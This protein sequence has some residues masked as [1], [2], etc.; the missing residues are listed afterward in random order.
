MASFNVTASLPKTTDFESDSV[1]DISLY[2]QFKT[3]LKADFIPPGGCLSSISYSTWELFN[4]LSSVVDVC[5][6]II[7]ILKKANCDTCKESL[8][9]NVT[10]SDLEKLVADIFNSQL[11]FSNKSQIFN[12]MRLKVL[13]SSDDSTSNTRK[14]ILCD[15]IIGY[16]F[17]GEI[18]AEHITEMLLL[19][20]SND[21]DRFFFVPKMIMK[22]FEHGTDDVI[23]RCLTKLHQQKLLHSICYSQMRD[24]RTPLFYEALSKGYLKTAILLQGS[25]A[26]QI[27][28]PSPSPSL[29]G[30]RVHLLDFVP[31]GCEKSAL[32]LLENMKIS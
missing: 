7:L 2:E 22:L 15:S 16:L 24:S 11:L 10:D 1:P 29:I 20:K 6:A 27:S 13:S 25:S 9:T 26:T 32:E 21:N 12:N 23:F 3:Q 17:Q 8:F 30:S 28:I 14:R 31:K 18:N 5:N 4:K 19:F